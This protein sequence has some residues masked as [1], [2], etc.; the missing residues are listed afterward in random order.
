MNCG[1][2]PG[3]RALSSAAVSAAAKRQKHTLV[4]VRCV[5]DGFGMSSVTCEVFAVCYRHGES[6]WN[7]ENKFT[8]WVDCP[9]SAN[10]NEEAIKAG[11]L[12]REN[13]FTF[14]VAYTSKLKRAIKTLW[15]SLEQTDCMSIPI[16]NAWELNERHYGALQGLDK[17]ETVKKFGKEQVNIWRRSYD[18]PPP[19]V[20]SSSPHFPGNDPKYANIP[21]ARDIKT[22][23]LKV[24]Q[25]ELELVNFR[26]LRALLLVVDYVG[27]SAALL[28]QHYCSY[29]QVRI[30]S[31]GCF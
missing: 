15:H 24:T 30:V 14:D 10:G 16:V 18:I 25:D 8:G 17:Q 28:D 13:N 7:K 26:E 11:A 19:A 3:L 21:E 6:S 20:D 27:K 31:I 29:R 4:L 23:S 2:V 5:Q 1:R 9:L 12:L 22:E